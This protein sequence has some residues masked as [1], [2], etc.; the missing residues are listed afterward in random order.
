MIVQIRKKWRFFCAHMVDFCR[1]GHK[2]LLNLFLGFEQ[3]IDK[4]F[5]CMLALVLTATGTSALA[6]AISA[7]APSATIAIV[8][9][10]I[11]IVVQMVRVLYSISFMLGIHVL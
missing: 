7:R 11:S 5:F 1:P 9:M 10:A 8:G 2:F 4:F 6:F 3:E